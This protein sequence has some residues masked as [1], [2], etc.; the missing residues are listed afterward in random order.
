MVQSFNVRFKYMGK[1]TVTEEL[2]LLS[3]IPYQNTS[4]SIKPLLTKPYQGFI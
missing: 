1:M 2:S 4:S 3:V